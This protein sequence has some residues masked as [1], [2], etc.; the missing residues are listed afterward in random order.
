[1]A[2]LGLGY[3]DLQA[4]NPRI[5]YCS[6]SGYGQS[7]PLANMAAHDL[8]YLAEAGMLALTAGVDGSSVLPPALIADIGGGAYPAVMN[9]LLAVMQRN[10]VGQAATSTCRW[11]TTCSRSCTG[12]WATAGRPSSG[13]D[14]G[15]RWSR[16]GSPRYN[17]YRTAARQVPGCRSAGAEVLGELHCVIET[18][19][20]STSSTRRARSAPWRR[21]SPLACRRVGATVRRRRRVRARV[22]S[23]REA[24][25][26]PTSSARG[27][28]QR[29]IQQREQ[30][31]P[32]LPA[33]TAPGFRAPDDRDGTQSSPGRGQRRH[34]G[35]GRR[36]QLKSRVV[37]QFE[38]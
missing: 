28:F 4:V 36:R 30:R 33:P 23:L 25:R 20:L 29:F 37:R 38:R 3:E 11:R 15:T 31:I 21:S 10:R 1:M 17:I 5:I 6:I 19:H 22:H 16:G 12:G 27:L 7:G 34:P 18:P 13:P 35:G 14:R 2:R 24:A 26:T 8:N 32:A 9:I